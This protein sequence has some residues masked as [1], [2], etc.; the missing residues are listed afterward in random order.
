M[1]L[2]K[3]RYVEQRGFQTFFENWKVKVLKKETL[4]RGTGT[5]SDIEHYDDSVDET[6]DN[7]VSDDE[8]SDYDDDSKFSHL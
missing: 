5:N 6:R 7:D 1:K 4:T 3:F 8:T 2:R